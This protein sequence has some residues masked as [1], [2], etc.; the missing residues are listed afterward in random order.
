MRV[1]KVPTGE[2]YALKIIAGNAIVARHLYSHEHGD[3]AFAEA[4]REVAVMK[5]LH[6]PRVVRLH[7]VIA[8][9][10]DPAMRKISL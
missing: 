9:W 3:E 10:A 4:R 6:H 1:K 7:E 8:D 5:K 2:F